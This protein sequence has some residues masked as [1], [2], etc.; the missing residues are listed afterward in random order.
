[1]FKNSAF[2]NF[3]RYIKRTQTVESQ[4]TR[5]Q[6]STQNTLKRDNEFKD[7]LCYQQA[8]VLALLNRYCSFEIERP[9]KE[10]T[11]TCTLPKVTKIKFGEYS[12]DI[13]KK[14]EDLTLKL[15]SDTEKKKLK[16]KT[17]KR[18]TAKSASAY[19]NNYMIDVL[20]ELGFF[21]NT[22]LSKKSSK[23]FRLERVSE[24]FYNGVLVFD[25]NQIQHMGREINTFFNEILKTS[26]TASFF[27]N[28]FTLTQKLGRTF[29]AQCLPL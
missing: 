24:I 15:T 23:S 1:M 25:R 17:V 4:I 20:S 22:K 21:F 16:E 6:M 2:P 3:H 14:A 12:V 27:K 28:D 29:I 26:K 11:I 8:V 7:M 13:R 9:G 5:I 18:R 19:V 10:S